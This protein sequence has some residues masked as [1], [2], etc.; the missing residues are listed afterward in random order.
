MDESALAEQELKPGGTVMIQYRTAI[1]PLYL[2]LVVIL[3]VIRNLY[4]T[5]I[6]LRYFIK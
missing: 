4:R 1:G 6:G 5:T 3:C 2:R